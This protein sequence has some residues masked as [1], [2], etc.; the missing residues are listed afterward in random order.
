MQAGD[1]VVVLVHLDRVGNSGPPTCQ[2][3]AIGPDRAVLISRHPSRA[4]RALSCCHVGHHPRDV[5]DR[6]RG[7]AVGGGE[8][9]SIACTELSSTTTDPQAAKAA[10]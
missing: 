1:D 2:A 6:A 9:V 8:A 5:A 3:T 7:H 10:E 4:S